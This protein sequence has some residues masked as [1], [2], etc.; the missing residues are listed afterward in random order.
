MTTR[1]YEVNHNWFTDGDDH[2]LPMYMLHIS[3]VDS[4]AYAIWWNGEQNPEEG[5]AR[6]GMGVSSSTA[7]ATA[8]ESALIKVNKRFMQR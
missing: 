4:S 6:A 8:A 7:E 3:S 2:T 5:A 1:T